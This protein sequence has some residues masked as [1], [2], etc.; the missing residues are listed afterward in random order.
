M[1]RHIFP[2]DLR[3][4]IFRDMEKEV[5]RA[6]II[7][8]RPTVAAGLDEAVQEAANLELQVQ[9]MVQEGEVVLPGSPILVLA[10]APVNLAVA[11]DRVPG[12]I[13]KASGVAAAARFFKTAL[14][15][16]LQVVCGGWKKLPLPWRTVL[17][18]AVSLGG[19]ATRIAEPPFLYIDK[20]Y[21]RMFGGIEAALKAVAHL[22]GKKAVQLRGERGGIAAEAEEA[23][24]GGAHILMADTGRFE[25]AARLS[26]FLRERGWREKV[27]LAFSGGITVRDLPLLLE[28]DLD[29]I[30]VGRAVLDAPMADL[31][32]EVRGRA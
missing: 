7:S 20:N 22:P 18:R 29:I 21:I 24:T 2:D 26:E 25:D 13:G 11:E 28:M 6:E 5:F 10:G 8:T 9:V 1:A 14:A 3:W 15:G 27:Q 4:S 23:V 31:R 19:L 16:K 32:F 12:W 30:D 17:R